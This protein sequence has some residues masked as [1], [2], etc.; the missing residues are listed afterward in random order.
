MWQDLPISQKN[1]YK[2]LILAFSSL[3]EMFVQKNIDINGLP[4]PIINSKFQETLFQKIFNAVAED[5]NNT[6]YDAS[7]ML[8]KDNS[9]KI[10]YLIGI[11]TFIFD[12]QEQKIAQFKA[13]SNEWNG[14]ILQIKDKAKN[15]KSKAEILNINKDNYLELAKKIATIRN[16]RINSSKANLRGFCIDN[17][18]IIESIYHTLMPAVQ[19][20]VPKFLWAK[21]HIQKLT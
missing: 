12:S 2:K 4:T 1:E 19:N 15:L 3:T 17:D 10:K 6:S 20:N 5:I 13:S 7:L 21:S 16:A 14:L 9:K 8:E 18:D 11:K